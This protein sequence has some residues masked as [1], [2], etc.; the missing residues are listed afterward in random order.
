MFLRSDFN[1]G[2]D[3]RIHK[4][5]NLPEQSHTPRNSGTRLGQAKERQSEVQ[6]LNLKIRH[7][8]QQNQKTIKTDHA[9]VA[10]TPS[11]YSTSRHPQVR[12]E[13]SIFTTPEVVYLKR[14]L[15]SK[16]TS[17]K[18][19]WANRRQA[20]QCL[21]LLRRLDS[22]SRLQSSSS[23]QIRRWVYRRLASQRCHS[24]DCQLRN[25][26]P[27]DTERNNAT[28]AQPAA[29]IFRAY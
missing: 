4:M 7:T 29:F 18:W 21:I 28:E 2:E 17:R 13:T 14:R 26:T 20:S 10:A 1:V 16:T 27:N 11:G 15:T 12:H 6:P 3:T 24:E 5:S 9:K 23:R 19:H 8:K 22:V 25:T